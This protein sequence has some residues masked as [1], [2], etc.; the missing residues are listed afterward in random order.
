[1]SAI[2]FTLITSFT[3]L[4]Q[5][6]VSIGIDIGQ[7]MNSGNI[8]LHAGY[9]FAEKWSA[10]YSVET[11]IVKNSTDIEYENH[12]SEFTEIQSPEISA[13]NHLL[14]VYYW[15]DET[16]KGAY[17]EFGCRSGEK[18]RTDCTLGIGYN[19]PIWKGLSIVLSYGTDLI[20][21]MKSGKTEGKGAG[22]S[23]CWTISTL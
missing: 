13:C 22:L 5:H 21:S 6:K 14:S 20:A 18:I 8:G 2:I 17:L 3:C 16:Y 10:S 9:G 7:I 15:F 12:L 19:I 1:M 23:I 11:D 4:A